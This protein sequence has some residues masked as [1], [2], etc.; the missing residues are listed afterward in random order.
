MT[1]TVSFNVT[2][3]SGRK[4]IQ[5]VRVEITTGDTVIGYF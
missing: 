2:V 4:D 3:F 1:F 5:A